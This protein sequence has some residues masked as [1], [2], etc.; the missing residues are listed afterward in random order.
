MSMAN[1]LEV[2]CPLLDHSLAELAGR[3]P[4]EWKT[5]GGKGKLILMRALADRLPNELLNRPKTG[6]ADFVIHGEQFVNSHAA[7]VAGLFALLT[8]AGADPSGSGR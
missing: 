8:A 2:R 1:S 4:N 7:F 5:R 3:I 6:F